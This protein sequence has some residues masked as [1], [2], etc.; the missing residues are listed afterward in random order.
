[1][2]DSVTFYKR[3]Y[4][5]LVPGMERFLVNG[6]LGSFEL[7]KAK[8]G[9]KSPPHTH[10]SEAIMYINSG[11]MKFTSGKEKIEERILKAGDA[12]YIKSYFP[13][14]IEIMEDTMFTVS[15]SPKVER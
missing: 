7:F 2:A 8:K 10:K 5:E 14:G 1:M 15:S 4:K 11:K 9:F 3:E 12:V 13:H 6:D